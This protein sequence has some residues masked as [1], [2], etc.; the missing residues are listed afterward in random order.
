MP[1]PE[2][3]GS[4]LDF[5]RWDEAAMATGIASIDEQHKE[6]FRHIN[7]LHRATLSGASLDDIR[8]VLHFLGRYVAT[9]F[10]HEESVMDEVKCPLRMENRRAHAR[11]LTEYRRLQS[12]FSDECD[13]DEVAVEIKKMTTR[14][15][16]THI[17]RIDVALR[18]EPV[19]SSAIPGAL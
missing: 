13:P 18:P 10:Q 14:W 11:F 5:V 1:A 15:L 19:E 6:L 2:L 17:C 9:H 16:T 4:D 3:P 8:K 12:E 7:E